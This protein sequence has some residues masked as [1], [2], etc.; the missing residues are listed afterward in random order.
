MEEIRVGDFVEVSGMASMNGFRR[1]MK[2]QGELLV[3]RGNY[4]IIEDS[5]GIPVVYL[6]K[7]IKSI[8]KVKKFENAI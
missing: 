8:K 7:D 1:Y 5:E 2:W 4:N 3:N 6:K